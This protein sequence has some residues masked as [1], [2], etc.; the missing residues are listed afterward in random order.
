MLCEKHATSFD[1]KQQQYI[2]LAKLYAF[3]EKILDS[4]FQN[5]VNNGIVVASRDDVNGTQIYPLGEIVNI[6]YNNTP[7]GSPG[8]RLL[9]DMWHDRAH[10]HFITEWYSSKLH[11]EFLEDV[12]LAILKGRQLPLGE[13]LRS[14]G[15]REGIPSAYYKK[16]TVESATT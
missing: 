16:P 5:S 9:V 4:H 15:V 13:N 14:T 1:A 3:G 12:L 11:H 7:N 2:H 8:R 10:A 6:I